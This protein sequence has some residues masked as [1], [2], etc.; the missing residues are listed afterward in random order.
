MLASAFFAT[1]VPSS[2]ANAAAANAAAARLFPPPG[3]ALRIDEASFARSGARINVHDSSFWTFA[4]TTDGDAANM[5][6]SLTVSWDAGSGLVAAV[7]EVLSRPAGSP[8]VDFM[9]YARLRRVSAASRLVAVNIHAQWHGRHAPRQPLMQRPVSLRGNPRWTEGDA[10]E[11]E[12]LSPRALVRVWPSGG[13]NSVERIDLRFDVRVDSGSTPEEIEVQGLCFERLPP[14]PRMPLQGNRVTLSPAR[15]AAAPSAPQAADAQLPS[16]IVLCVEGMPPEE[17]LRAWESRGLRVRTGLEAPPEEKVAAIYA[18][19]LS[20][21]GAEAARIAGYVSEGVPLILCAGRDGLQS[22]QAAASLERLLP[23]N[24]WS[25]KSR[26]ERGPCTAVAAKDSEFAA[27]TPPLSIPFARHFDLH[28]AGSAIESPM[29]R[30]EPGKWLRDAQTAVL[31]ETAEDGALPLLVAG[32]AAG[33]GRTIVFSADPEDATAMT[34]LRYVA[35]EEWLAA[36]PFAEWPIPGAAAPPRPSAPDAWARA[37]AREPFSI[38][39]EEDEESLG[40]L[41]GSPFPRE[42]IDGITSWRYVY[43]TG[44]PPKLR[45]RLRNHLANIAPLARTRDVLNPENFTVAGINDSALTHASTRGKL[46]IHA[47]WC[48]WNGSD[49]QEVELAW[50]EPVTLRGFRAWGFGPHRYWER[51]N[52]ASFSFAAKDGAP[53]FPVDGAAFSRFPFAPERAAWEAIPSLDELGGAMPVARAMTFSVSGLDPKANRE[54]RCDHA[55]NCALAELEVWGWAGE[56][57]ERPERTLSLRA[58]EEDLATGAASTNE[59]LAPAAIPFCSEVAV[60]ATLAPRDAFGPVRWRFQAI[61]DGAVVAESAFDALFV[62]DS[63]TKLQRKIG[64]HEADTGLLCTPGWRNVDPFGIGMNK[65][66]SGWGG[67]NDQAWALSQNLLEIGPGGKPDPGRMLSTVTRASHYTNP[68]GRFLDGASSWDWT[69][70]RLFD[71]AL[72]P[73]GRWAALEPDAIHVVG[74]DRWNGVNVWT[75]FRWDFFDAFDR[76]LRASGKPGLKGRTRTEIIAE[77]RESHG[78]EWQRFLMRDYA[79][80]MLATQRRAAE[81]GLRF[82][83]ETHGS[84]PLAGGELGADLARTHRGVGTDLF[85]DLHRQDLWWTLGERLALI[86]ANP[87]LESGAYDE[88]GWF[89]SEQNPFWFGSNGDIAPAR[90]QWYATYWLGRVALDGEFRPVHVMGFGSQGYHGVRYTARDHAARTRVTELMSQLRP[91][92]PAGVG[93]VVSWR[94]QERRMGP[95]LGRAGFGLYPEDGEADIESMASAVYSALVKQGAPVAFVTST[96]GL[97]NWKGANPLVLVDAP[98]WEDWEWDAVEEARGRGAAVLAIGAPHPRLANRRIVAA[99]ESAAGAARRDGTPAAAWCR[100]P[101]ERLGSPEAAAVWRAF[102]E[103]TGSP[104]A[105]SRGIVAVPFVSQGTRFLAVCRQGD[106]AG[107]A[108]VE[109]HPDAL[110]PTLAPAAPGALRAVSLDDG[111]ALPSETLPGGRMRFALPLAP[112]DGKIVMLSVVL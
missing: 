31:L 82:T 57:D 63:G 94:G 108:T 74:S 110:Y 29:V 60:D 48:G 16:G 39:V 107:D 87:D 106:D 54:P 92:E 13:A 47:V 71:S 96:H 67:P 15:D 98:N 73:R 4:D 91:E 17:M 21:S 89:N 68:W 35:F 80:L 28:L 102:S 85:W 90:R 25:A 43:R 12:E 93:L 105:V 20:L 38:A 51:S 26:L 42:G 109:L 86:A 10:H 72:D 19:S 49:R 88:W 23:V 77:I 56:P 112:C 30:Y 41:A 65:W 46:P 104:V 79:D 100:T 27:R 111:R 64:P 55:A 99:L 103:G 44:T 34:S 24:L 53:F 36:L 7:N 84:F 66:S 81:R 83:F 5:G 97:K 95:K 18:P 62:P 3:D 40:E 45:L 75:C 78:D 58:I 101:A 59:L 14:S 37:A 50:D 61:E 22:D 33:Q 11:I 1:A 52:P 8:P 69:A 2:A 70:D 9:A 32:E 76:H 6:S